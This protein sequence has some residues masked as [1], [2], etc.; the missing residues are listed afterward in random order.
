[1]NAITVFN[2]NSWPR[3]DLVVLP[4]EL[5]LPG[6]RVEDAA[7]KPVLSQRLTTGEFA[8]LAS[9]VPPLAGK[10]FTI[11]E[12]G[13]PTE[14]HLRVDGTTLA[15]AD[16]LVRVDPATGGVASLQSQRLAVELVDAKAATA[17]NDYF[18]LPGSDL[19]NLQRSGPVKISVKE[20]GPLVTSLLVDSEAPGC[21]RLSREIRLIEGLDRVDLVSATGASSGQS[22]RAGMGLRSTRMPP[23]SRLAAGSRAYCHRASLTG[24]FGSTSGIGRANNNGPQSTLA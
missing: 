11:K 19:K 6:E 15:G 22:Q 12:G 18:Y 1:V 9:E 10:S 4:R 20:S 8:F 13:K 7:G 16:L 3:T 24:V 14:T 17:V 5:P 2:T 23:S 21:N